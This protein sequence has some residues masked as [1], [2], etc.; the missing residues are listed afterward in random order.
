MVKEKST[1]A[2]AAA[3]IRK[4]LKAAFPQTKFSVT[5]DS[6]A[7]GDSVRISWVDGPADR[8]VK[9]IT[10]KFQ[11][12]HFDGMNDMYEYSNDRSDLPQSKYVQTSRSF[13][14]TV[15]E[16]TRQQL[17][18]D[19]GIAVWDDVAVYDKFGCW[20]STK[21]YRELCGKAF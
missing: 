10:D 1:Q 15:E 12:G 11:Y 6:F 9:E 18:K 20:G 14:D 8:Q 3:M 17:M 5:S 7:G 2:Q 4:E 13:S 19:Y 16:A 21:V